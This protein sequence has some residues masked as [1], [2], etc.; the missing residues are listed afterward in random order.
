MNLA[1]KFTNAA[2]I[3]NLIDAQ[4]GETVLKIKNP[5]LYF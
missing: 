3:T 5:Y 1:V 4:T 2:P